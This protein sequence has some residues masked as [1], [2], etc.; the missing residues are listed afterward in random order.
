MTAGKAKANI[1]IITV[2]QGKAHSYTVT[3]LA[4]PD[5][6]QAHTLIIMASP[7]IMA[8]PRSDIQHTLSSSEFQK[9]EKHRVPNL[10]NRLKPSLP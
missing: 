4:S 2:H 1:F 6:T 10:R 7:I 3:I 5:K 8:P 9:G